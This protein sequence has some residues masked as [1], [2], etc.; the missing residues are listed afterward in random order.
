MQTLIFGNLYET[1]YTVNDAC[2]LTVKEIPSA[3]NYTA[4][5]IMTQ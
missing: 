2:Y 4:F 1:I 5:F 3:R